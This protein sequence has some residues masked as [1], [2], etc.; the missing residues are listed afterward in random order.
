MTSI[1]RILDTYTLIVTA[2]TSCTTIAQLDTC[3][4]MITSMNQ[5]NDR[6][7]LSD[8]IKKIDETYMKKRAAIVAKSA[9]R[10]PATVEFEYQPTDIIN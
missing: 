6:S 4:Q 1:T 5:F 7:D 2:I 3:D 9:E 8:W 10:M